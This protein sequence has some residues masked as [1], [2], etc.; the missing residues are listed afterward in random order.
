MELSSIGDQVFAVESITKKRVRKVSLCTDIIYDGRL[1]GWPDVSI[2]AMLPEGNVE[3]L[4]KWQGWPQ[5]YSTWEPEDNILDPRLVIAYEESQEKIRALAY[6]RKGLRP[7]KLVLR[8]VFA[9]DL[10]SAHKVAVKP[11]PRLRLS[12]TRS[13]STDVEEGERAGMYRR[14]T[15]QRN[16]L[17]KRGPQLRALRLPPKKKE[18]SIEDKWSGTIENEKQETESVMEERRE[19]SEYGQSECSSPPLLER[20][21]VQD[22]V[23]EEKVDHLT[24]GGTQTWT[25]SAEATK[26]QSYVCDQ[27]EDSISAPE[28]CSG[29]AATN[30]DGSYWSDGEEEVESECP[31]LERIEDT[32]S[33]VANVQEKDDNENVTIATPAQA[34]PTSAEHAGKVIVTKVT[35]D[36]LT[37]IFKEAMMA[38]G[39]FKG[40]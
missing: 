5:K 36:S 12:L 20:Q 31:T 19:D 35:I 24:G 8:N 37:V 4:L 32:T 22:E 1:T 9:M 15:W 18:E 6:R 29:D 34:P 30:G 21:D 16:K 7:R 13:M 17:R 38:E 23:M 10:R 14:H 27:S 39:F 26:M 40:F 3:Y 2:A 11:P 25:D 28:A 33:V